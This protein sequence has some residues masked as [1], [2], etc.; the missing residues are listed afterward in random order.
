MSII[1]FDIKKN[2]NKIVGSCLHG[3]ISSLQMALKSTYN[4]IQNGQIQ[5]LEDHKRRQEDNKTG[6]IY[7]NHFLP[8]II[9]NYDY[10]NIDVI[11]CFNDLLHFCKMNCSIHFLRMQINIGIRLLD[12]KIKNYKKK[13]C[14]TCNFCKNLG[15]INHQHYNNL[16]AKITHLN[17]FLLSL[18]PKHYF[19]LVSSKPAPEIL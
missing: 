5:N 11:Q 8:Y 16:C 19:I 4:A 7:Y 6:L 17:G 14:V 3:Q 18:K 9:L 10:D 15:L 13:Y 2:T 1:K 12:K